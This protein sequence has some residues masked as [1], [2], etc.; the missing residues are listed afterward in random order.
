MSDHRLFVQG[1]KEG[2]EQKAVCVR[3]TG[4]PCAH[5]EIVDI[6][7]CSKQFLYNIKK[8][9]AEES[10]AWEPVS[11]GNDKIVDDDLLIGLL[12]KIEAY[13]TMRPQSGRQ[14]VP[15]HARDS[16]QASVGPA[17]PRGQLLLAAG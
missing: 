4:C 17:V 8:K 16:H 7:K 12:A 13:P 6:V 2:G 15:G 11:G 3:F 9:E 1:D 5:H 14:R 10:F